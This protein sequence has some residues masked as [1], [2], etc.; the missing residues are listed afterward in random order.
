MKFYFDALKDGVSNMNA[1]ARTDEYWGAVSPGSIIQPTLRNLNLEMSEVADIG[2]QRGI[3]FIDVDGDPHCWTGRCQA[4]GGPKHVVEYIPIHILELVRNRQL[5]LVIASDKEGYPF[6]YEDTDCFK[7]TNDAM[8]KHNLPIGSVYIMHGS[9]TIKDEY[10]SWLQTTAYPR[11]FE[12][13]YSN[14]FLKIFWSDLPTSPL[15]NDAM[16]NSE[17]KSFNSLNRVYRSHRNAHVTRLGILNLLDDGLVSCNSVSEGKDARAVQLL[18]ADFAREKEFAPRYVDGDWKDTNAANQFNDF[19]YKNSLLTVVT[20]TLFFESSVF[21][22]EKLFKP[23]V[24]GHPFITVASKGTLRGLESLGFRTDFALFS[25]PYDLIED[26][27]ERFNAIHENISEWA[28]LSREEQLQR[29]HNA[30]PTIEHNFNWARSSDFYGDA[31]RTCLAA[32]ENYF[33][34]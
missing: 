26:P 17:S 25:K 31:L 11:M 33:E 7:L 19:V 15:I 34:S 23:L 20:E 18:G 28:N 8:H 30:M 1:H 29:L 13:A 10:E 2:S 27:V 22:T 32:A 4:D 14:H 9:Q 12:V 21:I 5:R 16:Q 6:V 24:L 3:Y